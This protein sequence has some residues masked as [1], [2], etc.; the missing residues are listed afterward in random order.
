MTLVAEF[1]RCY[2]AIQFQQI[3]R[4]DDPKTFW[5]IIGVL[6]MATTALAALSTVFFARWISN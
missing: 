2:T 4:T 3:R 6:I 5:L 1:S